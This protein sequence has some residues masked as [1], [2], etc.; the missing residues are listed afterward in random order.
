MVCS[1]NKEV[2]VYFT[3]ISNLA[4]TARVTV[5]NVRADFFLKGTFITEQ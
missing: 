4:V 5:N 3:I 2:A 1:S